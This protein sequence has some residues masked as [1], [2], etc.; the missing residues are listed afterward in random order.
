MIIEYIT[1]LYQYNAWANQRILEAAARLSPEQQREKIGSSFDSIHDTLTH[2]MSA[3]WIWLS[4]W[5]G[6]SPTA[7]LKPADFPDLEAIRRR[8]AEI[9]AETQAFVQAL[10]EER[11]GQALPYSTTQ[12]V[13]K[14]SPLWQ[15]M[16]HQ[17]NHGTQHRSEVAAML[18]H[19]NQSPGGLDMILYFD[20][21]RTA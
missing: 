21:Q 13:P 8:W 5:Q 17:V 11:L 18:T 10:D 3:H 15:L 6:V 19:M 20:L 1:M 9:E 14:A 4:R 12:G 7:M 2:T 16:V